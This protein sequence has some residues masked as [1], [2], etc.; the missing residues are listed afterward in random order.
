M[1]K[2]KTKTEKTETKSLDAKEKLKLLKEELNKLKLD[3]VQGKLKNTS[4]LTLKRK[5]I[6]KLLTAM[7]EKQL[8]ENT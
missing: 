1:A 5:E 4:F 2:L 8:N 6:A 3:H 7:R